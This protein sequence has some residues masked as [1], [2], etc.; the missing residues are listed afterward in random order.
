MK[1]VNQQLRTFILKERRGWS[2][3]IEGAHYW[4]ENRLK[5]QQG[6]ST[7]RLGCY[8]VF[9]FRNFEA[10]HSGRICFHSKHVTQTQT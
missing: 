4:K 6:E 1:D 2:S 10:L 5:S 9:S 3:K 8:V 7:R